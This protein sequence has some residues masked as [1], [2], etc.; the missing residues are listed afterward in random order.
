MTRISWSF[1]PTAARCEPGRDDGGED[2]S[3]ERILD[4]PDAHYL[5][6]PAVAELMAVP[7]ASP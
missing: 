7:M 2:A 1:N 4:D 3:N 6:I 5:D